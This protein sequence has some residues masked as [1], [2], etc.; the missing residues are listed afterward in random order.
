MPPRSI[1]TSKEVL[2]ARVGG[3]VVRQVFPQY[4]VERHEDVWIQAFPSVKQVFQKG[5]NSKESLPFRP[6][7]YQ[8]EDAA[9]FEASDISVSKVECNDLDVRNPF[10]PEK[11]SDNMTS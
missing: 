9:I 5:G 8:G 11:F 3:L 2:N 7:A 10:V 1:S 6:L 4:Y